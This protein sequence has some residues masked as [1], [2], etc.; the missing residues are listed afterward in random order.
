MLI[1]LTTADFPNPG[2]AWPEADFLVQRRGRL[3]VITPQTDAAW[4]WLSE[5]VREE[6]FD[7]AY[8]LAVLD[9][10]LAAL[11]ELDGLKGALV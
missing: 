2:T 7:F 1:Q 4:E 3:T 9:G 6:G 5:H 10:R 11:M 8:S